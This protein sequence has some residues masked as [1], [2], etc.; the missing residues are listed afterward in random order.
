[1]VEARNDLEAKTLE[2]VQT[3][4]MQ[5]V[6]QLTGGLAHDFNNLLMIVLGNLELVQQ[7]LSD[8]D[9]AICEQI[10][11]AYQAAARGCNLVAQLMAFSRKQSLRAESI[12]AAGLIRRIRPLLARTLG[13]TSM[14][15]SAPGTPLRPVG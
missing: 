10:E 11:S 12:D 14:L 9:G 1:M 6:G 15:K 13:G 2:L 7:S 5:A 8:S 3:Q 4:K